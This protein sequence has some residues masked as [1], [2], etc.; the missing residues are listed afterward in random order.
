M[1]HSRMVSSA[2]PETITRSYIP[3]FLGVDMTVHIS[4]TAL[5]QKFHRSDIR[6]S[7]SSQALASI[8]RAKTTGARLH[9][10]GF[11]VGL[12]HLLAVIYP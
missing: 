11:K 10:I 3:Q 5:P 1:R 7:V 4:H 9:I 2:T 12:P 8:G 6:S